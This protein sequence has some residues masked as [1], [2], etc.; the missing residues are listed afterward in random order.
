M[1]DHTCNSHGFP[2][3]NIHNLKKKLTAKKQKRKLL[4]TTT[5]ETKKYVTFSYHSPLTRKTTNL[6]KYTNL[7]VALRATNNSLTI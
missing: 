1:K 2:L 7:N 6:F 3:H 4:T 5:Q